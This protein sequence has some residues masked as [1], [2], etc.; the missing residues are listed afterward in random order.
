MHAYTSSYSAEDTIN[1]TVYVL[2][3]F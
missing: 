2:S 3:V 1:M